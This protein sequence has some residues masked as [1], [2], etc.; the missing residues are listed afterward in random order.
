MAAIAASML[1]LLLAGCQ[2]DQNVPSATDF[3]KE[4]E[5]IVKRVAAP[6][7]KQSAHNPAPATAVAKVD[8]DGFL[9]PSGSMRYDPV[10]MRDPFRSLE[11]KRQELQEVELGGPLEQ[12]DLSQLDVLAVV[13]KTG[14]PRAL[15]HDPAGRSYIV[16]VG[17]RVGKNE[18]TV[19]GIDD[20]LV[21]VKETY[22]DYLGHE[23]KQDVEMRIRPS[24][25][26]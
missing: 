3:A 15:V 25:G 19:V 11:W 22:V 16:A 18:G 24:E 9:V 26:G 23:T 10:T 21:I 20:N 12:F 13:W 8:T 14:S 5:R 2:Q 17:A 4:R 7:E 1:F 6:R